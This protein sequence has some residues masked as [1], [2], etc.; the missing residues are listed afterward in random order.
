MGLSISDHDNNIARI[1]NHCF[2]N[3][4]LNLTTANVGL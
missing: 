3:N 4:Y 2:R 1:V